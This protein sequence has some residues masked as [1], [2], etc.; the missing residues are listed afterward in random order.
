MDTNRWSG[1]LYKQV[2]VSATFKI[3]ILSGLVVGCGVLTAECKKPLALNRE[4]KI[5]IKKYGKNISDGYR[6]PKYSE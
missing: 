6:K 3:L 2:A 1:Y 4:V 5:S